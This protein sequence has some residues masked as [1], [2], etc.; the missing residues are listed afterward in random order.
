MFKLKANEKGLEL[1]LDYDSL[2]SCLP[3]VFIIDENRLKQIIINL[4][5][6]AIKYT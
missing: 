1:K 4:V 2:Y 5:S 3:E 6:N